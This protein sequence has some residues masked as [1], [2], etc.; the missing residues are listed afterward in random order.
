MRETGKKGNFSLSLSFSCSL[1]V[2]RSRLLTSPKV[3]LSVIWHPTHQDAGE[4]A[5]EPVEGVATGAEP[6]AAAGGAPAAGAAA[7]AP[8]GALPPPL[9]CCLLLLF[10]ILQGL[11]FSPDSN[12]K[13]K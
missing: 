5:R 3:V 6:V 4:E 2:A 10:D 1:S 12:Q 11:S 13:R 8:A 7:A 9:P